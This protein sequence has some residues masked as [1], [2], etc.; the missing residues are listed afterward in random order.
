MS[1]ANGKQK[2]STSPMPENEKQLEKDEKQ[3]LTNEASNGYHHFEQV[4]DKIKQY[5][6][7]QVFMFVLIQYIML[8]A[9]GNYVFISFA[10]LKP[11]CLIR[12]I[13]VS[14][15][16]CMVTLQDEKCFF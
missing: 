12:E 5:G 7:Y 13:N 3:S 14:F 4:F 16:R 15:F 10:A 6:K 1:N 9:A 8:N 2:V 11:Q